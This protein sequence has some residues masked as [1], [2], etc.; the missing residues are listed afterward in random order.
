MFKPTDL[1]PTSNA[2]RLIARAHQAALERRAARCHGLVHTSG[3]R[4]P[5]LACPVAYAI[6][7]PCIELD[8]RKHQMSDGIWEVLRAAA[9]SFLGRLLVEAFARRGYRDA[10]GGDPSRC[11]LEFRDAPPSILQT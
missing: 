3:T 7:R 4:R 11:V 1:A 10:I 8:G 2:P 5:Q 6:P 9:G